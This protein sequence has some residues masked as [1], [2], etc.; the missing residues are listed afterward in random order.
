[1]WLVKGDSDKMKISPHGT[2]CP[3]QKKR[4]VI[5]VKGDSDKMEFHMKQKNAPNTLGLSLSV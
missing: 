3:A 2:M 4:Y 1:M 5:R